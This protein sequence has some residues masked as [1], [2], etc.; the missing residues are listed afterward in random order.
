VRV[1][2]IELLNFRSSQELKLA[3]PEEQLALVG[4]NGSGKTSVLEAVWYA[5]SLGSHRTSTDAVMVR[6]GETA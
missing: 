4:P 3:M 1:A 2:A 6:S 5:A